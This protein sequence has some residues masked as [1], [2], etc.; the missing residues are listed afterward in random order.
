MCLTT[1]NS[2][3]QQS[4]MWMLSNEIN[5]NARNTSDDFTFFDD[6]EIIGNYDENMFQNNNNISNQINNY[7]KR[8]LISSNNM[9]RPKFV[10]N[11][12]MGT[13]DQIKVRSNATKEIH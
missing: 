8:E 11:S 6:Q 3:Q 9:K 4:M 13:S 10:R 5:T 2:K 12:K 7:C 1:D